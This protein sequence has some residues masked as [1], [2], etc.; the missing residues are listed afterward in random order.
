MN[1]KTLLILAILAVVAAGLALVGQRDDASTASSLVGTAL[2]PQLA[3]SLDSASAILIETGGAQTS[4]TLQRQ[5]DSW[6][7]AEHDGYPADFG[8]LRA[9]LT[10]LAQARVVEEKTRNPDFYDRLGVQPLD[11]AEAT[12]TGVRI[13]DGSQDLVNIVLGATSGPSGRFA[14]A[15]ESD[16]SVLIDRNPEIPADPTEWLL[17]Q[18]LDVRG[19]RVQR[20][21]ITHADGEV[22][23]LSKAARGQANF[24]VASIPDGRELQYESVANVTGNALSELRL[25]GARAATDAAADADPAVTAEFRTFDGL[26]VTTTDRAGDG[27]L[28]FAARFDPALAREFSETALEDADEAPSDEAAAD[29]VIQAE[30]DGINDRTSNWA[31]ELP[32]HI[33]GQIT[34][35]IEDLLKALPDEAS[36]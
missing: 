4:V 12:G 29:A 25:Q 7:V 8:K 13:R 19:D 26:I 16:V 35:R 5:G 24:T 22:L 33:H 20:V 14:R 28:S 3:E 11:A 1:S 9:A 34:R 30:A 6:T 21:T 36:D 23:E 18:L 31:F 32:S 17:P 2:A 10:D 27:W 15:A